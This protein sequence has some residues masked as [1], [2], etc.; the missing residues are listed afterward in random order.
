MRQHL[1]ALALAALSASPALAQ[2]EEELDA[3]VGAIASGLIGDSDAEGVFE[4]YPAEH[5]VV[6]RHIRSG[7][8]CRMPET[9]ANRL[10]IFPEAARGE[11]VACETSDG[12][13]TIRI[14]AT[15]FSFATTLRA[16]ID[17]AAAV[18]QRQHPD[19][20]P[21][22]AATAIADSGQP[23]SRTAQFI[24]AANGA[25]SY[26]RVSVALVDGWVIKLRYTAPAA[27]DAA[28]R[29]AA[30]LSGRYWAG[31]LDDLQR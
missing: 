29:E 28:A 8:I 21:F 7:L 10:I 3:S 18:I 31:L 19:A 27:N 4:V 11:D 1:C 20:Q 26:T 30:Q 13:E 22:T 15:R 12:R 17:G 5:D 23:A 25:R 14:F 9:S 2:V 6:V 24:I 16:Q